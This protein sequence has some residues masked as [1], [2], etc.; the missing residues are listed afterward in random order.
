M[1]HDILADTFCVIKNMESIGKKECIVPASKIIKSILGIMQEHKYIGDFK[2]IDDGRGGKF[3]VNLIGKI[4]NCNV[5]RPRSS[6]KR[7]DFIKWEKRFLPAN[8]VGILI[9]TTSRGIVDQHKAKKD[10]IGGK[11]LGYVY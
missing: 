2:F 3:S 1:R 4:N 6:L 8:N 10:G 7:D 11:L 9:I 5:I